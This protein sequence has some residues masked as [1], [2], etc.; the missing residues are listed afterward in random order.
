MSKESPSVQYGEVLSRVRASAL[1]INVVLC[2]ALTGCRGGKESGSVDLGVDAGGADAGQVDA[3]QVDASGALDGGAEDGGEPDGGESDAEA[4]DAGSVDPLSR[5]TPLFNEGTNLEPALRE[6]TPGAL[7]SRFA[8]RGRDRHARE[9]QFQAYEHYLPL[10][11]E[12]RTAQIEIVDTVGRGGDTITFNVTTE[13]R[14]QAMQAELRLFFRGLNTVAE[15]HD[16]RPMTR[17]DD[18]HYTHAVSF[19]AREGRPLQVGDRM[20]FELSQFLDAPPRGRSNY[21]GT[22]FLYVVGQGIEPWLG[23]GPIRDSQ[24]LASAARLG[25]MTTLHRN[26][27]NE[28]EF[29][30]SQMATNI[31]PQNA[32]PFMRGRR[33]AHT[34]FSDGRHDESA[35]NPVWQAQSGKLGP[36]YIDVSCNACHLR[37]G[38]AP[39]PREGEALRGFVVKLGDAKG[40]PHP[41][42]GGVLQPSDTSEPT[43]SLARW[44]AQDALRR[45]IYE[46]EGATL[47]RYSARISPQLVGMGLLEAIPELAIAANAD[48]QDL[49]GDGISGRMSIVVDARTTQERLGRFGWKAGQATVLQ[50]VASAL[51]TDMG[52]L[53]SVFPDADCGAEQSNCTQGAE[54]DDPQLRDLALYVAL[55]GVPPQAN[56]EDPE[57]VQGRALFEEVGCARC[58]VPSF[59]TSEFAVQA[60]LRSQSI[61]PFTD[62]LLHDMGP[63]LADALSEGEASGA[64]WRTPPLWGIGK[65]AGVSGAVS[66]LHDGRARTLEEAIR[67]H[68]GEAEQ[69]TDGFLALT[70]QERARLLTFVRSL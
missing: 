3:G 32:Q 60:E 26:E 45:P 29:V 19:N 67:W 42:Y 59:V 28:P 17:I 39:A 53:S 52:V 34:N 9:D 25:G 22:V 12:H 69:V 51:R 35:E 36:R 56:S 7:I 41:E 33:L 8:D 27:S 44:D 61:S 5:I 30:F 57:V 63:D 18:L 68:G 47:E 55:L 46:F 54:L 21:Y 64:E 24:P 20:E 62:L 15:Y 1:P 4:V 31:A 58:H 38:R 10:Y 14:L 50:Q 40:G 13:W 49:D 16:N 66:Y 37:N 65:T 43:V 23:Q 70:P 2:F 48:P 11:W 6:D